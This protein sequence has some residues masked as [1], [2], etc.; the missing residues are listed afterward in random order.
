MEKQ[1]VAI[2]E[3]P[4]EAKTTYRLMNKDDLKKKKVIIKETPVSVKTAYNFN[5][6]ERIHFEVEN[7]N[8]I[9]SIDI[10]IKKRKIP[11]SI[12]FRF[13]QLVNVKG[14]NFKYYIHDCYYPQKNHSCKVFPCSC[15]ND[16]KRQFVELRYYL[17][18]NNW[19]FDWKKHFKIKLSEFYDKIYK[20][21]PWFVKVNL[22]EDFEEMLRMLK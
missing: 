13:E 11:K 16:P 15:Q 3:T 8:D 10:T 2:K 18:G 21:I 12:R 6:D 4:V 17:Q 9:A 14:R 7:E 19:G 1:K 22:E 5:K 20:I